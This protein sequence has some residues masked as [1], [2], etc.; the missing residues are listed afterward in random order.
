MLPLPGNAQV[1]PES[2]MRPPRSLA[3]NDIPPETLGCS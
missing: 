3:G 1:L 2:R